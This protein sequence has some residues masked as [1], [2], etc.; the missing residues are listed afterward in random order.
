MTTVPITS[1][2][3]DGFSTHATA[4]WLVCFPDAGESAAA[5]RYWRNWLSSYRVLT[6]ELPG[7]GIYHDSAPVR[8]MA[9]LMVVVE[10]LLLGICTSPYALFGHGTGA[11]IAYE[12]ARRE[13]FRGRPPLHLFL[14]GSRAPHIEPLPPAGVASLHPTELSE[15]HA[16]PPFEAD[17]LIDTTYR[18]PPS[19]PLSIPFTVFGG[20][21][22]D[23][24]PQE[25]LLAWRQH[26]AFTCTYRFLPSQDLFLLHEHERLVTSS[27]RSILD[28]CL[29]G[30]EVDSEASVDPSASWAAA[31][32]AR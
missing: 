3:E 23:R 7:R 24:V 30:G 1:G 16:L 25:A 14:S 26:S 21:T 4:P 12:A 9:E 28:A 15:D 10:P 20:A 18:Q 17:L 6:V 32:G 31:A 13:T 11:L 22:D 2:K 19:P 8:S 27:I 5:Y 29:E